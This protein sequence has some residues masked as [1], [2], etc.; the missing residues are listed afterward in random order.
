MYY[1]PGYYAYSEK[2]TYLNH[3]ISAGSSLEKGKKSIDEINMFLDND[4]DLNLVALW[5]DS[6]DWVGHRYDRHSKEVCVAY[7]A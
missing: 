2:P 3:P 5:V 1:W 6:P 4:P 7:I